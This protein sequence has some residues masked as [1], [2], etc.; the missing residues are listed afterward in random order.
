MDLHFYQYKIGQGEL[1]H[2]EM[3]SSLTEVFFVEN[4]KQSVSPFVEQI[5]TV[6]T[7]QDTNPILKNNILRG[8]HLRDE[9]Y[10]RIIDYPSLPLQF[11]EKGYF[12]SKDIELGLSGSEI[13]DYEGHFLNEE[14]EYFYVT[15]HPFSQWH[16]CSFVCDNITF[17][18]TEQFMMYSKALLFGDMEIANKILLSK[19]VREQKNL[20]RSVKRFDIKVWNQQAINIVYKGNKAKF[21]QSEEFKSLLLSTQGKTLVEASPTDTVWGIGREETNSNASN[22]W[23]WKGTNWLGIVLTELREEL[24]GNTFENGYM[25]HEDYKKLVLKKHSIS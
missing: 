3:H 12:N 1:Q 8:L 5:R 21:S 7:Q 15:K 9:K 11:V 25:R 13:A 24:L 23:F 10:T 17:N 2:A 4:F 14:Y 22:I 6:L 20:G 18:S 19:D 16:K